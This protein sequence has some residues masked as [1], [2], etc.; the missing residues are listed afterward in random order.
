MNQKCLYAFPSLK[1]SGNPDRAGEMVLER[2]VRNNG[3]LL[4]QGWNE[5][6]R[7]SRSLALIEVY[8]EKK[9]ADF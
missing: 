2:I 3:S 7:L 5:H 4:E 9:V 6:Q 8:Y 1:L